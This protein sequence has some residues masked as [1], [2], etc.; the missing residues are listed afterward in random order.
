MSEGLD[1]TKLPMHDLS[2]AGSLGKTTGDSKPALAVRK[3]GTKRGGVF[4]DGIH[5]RY[6]GGQLRSLLSLISYL[7]SG[8][9]R[10]RYLGVKLPPTNIQDYRLEAARKS[11]DGLAG[12]LASTGEHRRALASFTSKDTIDWGSN[13]W[14]QPAHRGR[15][16]PG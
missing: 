8:D 11:A 12:R 1:R 14:R 13:D 10:E 7:G 16:P 4:A 9:Y 2:F 5:L 15:Y 3:L 6:Q